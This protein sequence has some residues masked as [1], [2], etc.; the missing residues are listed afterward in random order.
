MTSLNEIIKYK[1]KKK[2]KP[3][4]IK[5]RGDLRHC[6]ENKSMKRKD[7][8]HC[9]Q[10]KGMVILL[11]KLSPRK[12]NSAVRKGAKVQIISPNRKIRAYIPGMGHTLTKYAT[13]L[14]RGGNIKDLPGMKYTLV[15]GKFDFHPLPGKYRKQ[16]RSKYGVK[17]DL[18]YHGKSMTDRRYKKKKY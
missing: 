15:R 1:Y 6:K 12:P 2:P 18:Q 13:V 16:S 7:L 17:L 5:R 11:L 9:P 10:R 8:K 14:I 3:R 4:K